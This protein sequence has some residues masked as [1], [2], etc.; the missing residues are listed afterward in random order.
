MTTKINLILVAASILL[1]S[2]APSFGESLIKMEMKLIRDGETIS[3]PT[4]VMGED[5]ASFAQEMEDDQLAVR[6]ELKPKHVTEQSVELSLRYSFE[7]LDSTEVE[8]G[9]REFLLTWGST[10]T[11]QFA[12]PAASD[13]EDTHLILNLTASEIT[14]AEVDEMRR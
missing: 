12:Y 7:R 14:Q 4:L 9:E 5:G 3:T 2:P 10:K 1:F 8:D 13:G 6:Y 11:T